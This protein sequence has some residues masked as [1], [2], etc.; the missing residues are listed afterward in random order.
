MAIFPAI[1]PAILPGSGEI[2]R[3][4]GAPFKTMTA[5]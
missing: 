4:L 3:P 2:D 5:S 1:F